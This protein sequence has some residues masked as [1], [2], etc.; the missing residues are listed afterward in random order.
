[1]GLTIRSCIE[2]TFNQVLLHRGTGTLGIVVEQEQTLGQLSIV[3]SFSSQHVGSNS[4]EVTLLNQRLDALAIVLLTDSIQLVVESKLLNVVKILLL[5]VRRG[6][7]VIGIH[8]GKD[9]LEHTASC[10]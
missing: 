8:K 2:R 4:L 9:V 10:T 3:Q 1:M 7:V 6:L 5:K